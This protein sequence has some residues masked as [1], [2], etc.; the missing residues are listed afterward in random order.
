LNGGT[1]DNLARLGSA[2][3]IWAIA[4]VHG[5]AERLQR[6]HDRIAYTLQPDGTWQRQRLQP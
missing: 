1:K 4:A 6:L 2:G 5:E 3:R